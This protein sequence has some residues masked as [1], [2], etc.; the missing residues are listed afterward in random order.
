MPDAKVVL[1]KK[2]YKTLREPDYKGAY[3]SGRDYAE[4]V[5]EEKLFWLE[6]GKPL[7]ELR[8]KK[9]FLEQF[10]EHEDALAKFVK[11]EKIDFKDE[12]DLR[13]LFGYLNELLS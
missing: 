8:N 10:P 6:R 1:Y 7:K 9:I 4:F 12:N 3:S 2:I 13:Q 11:K 5:S